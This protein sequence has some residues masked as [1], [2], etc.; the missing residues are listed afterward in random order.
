MLQIHPHQVQPEHLPPLS[1]ILFAFSGAVIL[2]LCT[3]GGCFTLNMRENAWSQAARTSEN[4]LRS[5]ERTL[6]RDIQLY[7][8][9]LQA[10]VEGLQNPALEGLSPEIQRL[11]LFDRAATAP[12]FGA[13]FVLDQLGRAYIDSGSA[14]PRLLNASERDYYR[15]HRDRADVGLF[16]GRP[17]TASPT[18]RVVIPMS[19][20]FTYADGTF[21][22]VVV[23]G[24]EV[25][26]FAELFRRLNIEP[27]SAI[28]LF[29]D[30]G[31]LLVR[32]PAGHVPLGRDMS[33]TPNVRRFISEDADQ[34]RAISAMD[35]VERFYT[36]SR[37]GS[38]PLRVNA[39]LSV[40]AIDASWRPRA[41]I[42]GLLVV[43]MCC[44]VGVLMMWVDGELRRRVKAE[45]AA[46]AASQELARLAATDG[47]TGLANRRQFDGAL[48]SAMRHADAC[49]VALLLFD[50]DQFK[51]YND[52]YGHLAG[53]QVLK[54][55]ARV[56]Q[57]QVCDTS[58][59]AC[60]IGGEEFAVIL[61]GMDEAGA[62]ACAERVRQAIAAKSIPHAGL[63]RGAVTVSA[64][65]I[66]LSRHSDLTGEQWYAAADAALYQ[67]KRQGRNQVWIADAKTGELSRFSPHRSTCST[68]QETRRSG[69]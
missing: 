30:D 52:I 65:V 67:A 36:F 9:S 26:H 17:V 11:S 64:G 28:N 69:T 42:V 45:R 32:T 62:V 46:Q 53:D 43:V 5:I 18:G 56:L 40:Q 8:L 58:G 20:R 41:G 22:G 7:D 25:A 63:S 12:G 15:V 57:Q 44:G 1:R 55:I 3:L 35:G 23:G 68:I 50:A 6:D 48:A 60:R 34:F 38:W 19:R 47:L 39:A 29:R 24:I 27:D 2:A 14:V 21:A 31:M 49:P 54:T 10:V 51:R 59:L 4:L 66:H 61:S 16:I 13:M 33:F 37:V